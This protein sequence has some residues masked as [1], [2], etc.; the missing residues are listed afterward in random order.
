MASQ[1]LGHVLAIGA[2]YASPCAN[3]VCGITLSALPCSSESAD[4]VGTAFRGVGY[5]VSR[6]RG[7]VTTGRVS[8]LIQDITT[9]KMA[10][11]SVLVVY[12]CGH[13]V[14][15]DLHQQ[16]VMESGHLVPVHDIVALVSR[17]VLERGLRN[18][19][20]LLMMDCC[21]HSCNNGPSRIVAACVF[22]C[23]KASVR[24]TAF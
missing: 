3:P 16:L 5:R 23:E 13:G 20:L 19:S 24:A 15:V 21:R 14:A 7:R 4:R 6:L 8:Q 2:T 1:P 9:T 12:F 17:I 22:V 18:V 11:N 10:S